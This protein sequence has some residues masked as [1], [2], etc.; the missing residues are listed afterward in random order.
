MAAT[1]NKKLQHVATFMSLA[2]K[3]RAVILNCFVVLCLQGDSGGPLQC[4]GLL[5]G[6]VSWGEECALPNYPG[7]YADV[8]YYKDWIAQ[9]LVKSRTKFIFRM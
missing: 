9:Q 5:T 4:G 8:A 3:R 7:V 6:V 2:T 1:F